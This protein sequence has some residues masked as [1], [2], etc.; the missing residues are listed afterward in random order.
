M[1]S[2]EEARKESPEG[3]QGAN[4]GFR[5]QRI[6][7]KEFRARI[8]C[9]AIDR[10]ESLRC[11]RKRFI[12]LQHP[13]EVL[14]RLIQPVEDVSQHSGSAPLEDSGGTGDR[15][16]RGD[17]RQKVSSR[18][19]P[20]IRET[21]MKPCGVPGFRDDSR[22][23]VPERIRGSGRPRIGHAM[24]ADHQIGRRHRDRLEAERDQRHGRSLRNRGEI[25]C[26]EAASA[27]FG[28]LVCPASQQEFA[29]AV[30]AA[31]ARILVKN[32]VRHRRKLQNRTRCGRTEDSPGEPDYQQPTRAT[33]S[34]CQNG[35]FTRCTKETIHHGRNVRGKNRRGQAARPAKVREPRAAGGR[36]DVS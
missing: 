8:D 36:E 27:G 30:S 9:G 23:L 17:L 12:S 15:C 26:E 18:R 5:D 14:A 1:P 34:R 28:T 29:G 25:E 31:T 2:S 20:L 33:A 11:L 13:A 4:P 35:E 3:K 7:E 16:D 6:L 10:Y 32:R 19:S 22:G 21:G 24:Q